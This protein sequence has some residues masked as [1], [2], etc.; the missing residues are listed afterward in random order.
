MAAAGCVNSASGCLINLR[1]AALSFLAAATSTARKHCKRRRG[2]DQTKSLQQNGGSSLEVTEEPQRSLQ[3]RLPPEVIEAIVHLHRRGELRTLAAC[4]A[5]CR[6]FQ[7]I[8]RPLLARA[9]QCRA[10]RAPLLH[11]RDVDLSATG[12][13]GPLGFGAVRM[14]L[15]EDGPALVL[16]GRQPSLV[17]R[18]GGLLVPSMLRAQDATAGIQ[19]A[20]R[21][22]VRLLTHLA[23]SR[24]QQAQK[25]KRTRPRAAAMALG[26]ESA[27]DSSSGSDQEAPAAATAVSQGRSHFEMLSCGGCG[28]FLGERWSGGPGRHEAAEGPSITVLCAH[29]LRE[30]DEEGPTKERHFPLHCSGARRQRQ[31]PGA[32][33]GSA[34]GQLLA[35]LGDVLSKQHCWRPVGGSIEDAWYLNSFQPGAVSAGPNYARRLGQGPM[36]VRN[37]WCTSCG[38]N[39]GWQFA[40]DL[41]AG[42]RNKH[43]VGR[44]GLCGS[45]IQE[46][47]SAADLPPPFMGPGPVSSS[48]SEANLEEGDEE[49]VDS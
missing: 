15:F 39:V 22:A 14:R 2:A 20:C 12:L 19:H 27:Q 32:P 31:V 37:V 3:L 4:A 9:V 46:L 43:Q 16:A 38:A 5:T 42:Q 49:E 21:A 48:E 18:P 30:V 35:C 28:L 41:T 40:K 23:E 8:C 36:E 1:P 45:S 33:A 44:Y 11:A 34:C 29:Y 17:P 6:L 7:R 10:C 24:H 47:R 26:E 25:P 13:D